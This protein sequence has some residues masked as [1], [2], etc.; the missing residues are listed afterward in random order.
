MIKSHELGPHAQAAVHAGHAKAVCTFRDPR[1]CVASDLVFMNVGLEECIGRVNLTLE[2]L[3]QFQTTRNILLV[4][5]EDMIVDRRQEIRRIAAHLGINVSASAISRIDDKTNIQSS[6]NVCRSLKDRPSSSLI[7]IQSHR[8]D[9]ETHLHENHINDAKVGK[10][11]TV[12]SAEQGRW[13]TEYFASWLLKLGY[14]TPASLAVI[15]RGSQ[16]VELVPTLRSP[17]LGTRSVVTSFG[18]AGSKPD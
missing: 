7:D 15:T 3:N 8:V 13:L 16:Q 17:L 4:R 1:D 9:P 18:R 6:R 10:W 5:Y 14:E 2:F 12:F 11:K